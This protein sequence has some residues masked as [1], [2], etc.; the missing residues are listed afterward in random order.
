MEYYNIEK[1]DVDV[2]WRCENGNTDTLVRNGAAEEN[3]NYEY[4][5]EDFIVCYKDTF[6]CAHGFFSTNNNVPHDVQISIEK[7]PEGFR[8]KYVTDQ[9]KYEIILDN[10]RQIMRENDVSESP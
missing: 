7:T 6:L 8:V 1:T 9:D 3:L 2:I 10:C 5:H 4:G